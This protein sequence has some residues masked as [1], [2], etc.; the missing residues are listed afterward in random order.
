MVFRFKNGVEVCDCILKAASCLSGLYKNLFL[1]HTTCTLA[2]LPLLAIP[3]VALF[4]GFLVARLWIT[5]QV[6]RQTNLW[7]QVLTSM[8]F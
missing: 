7:T 3:S 4:R 8:R 2:R 6:E 1:V 5:F